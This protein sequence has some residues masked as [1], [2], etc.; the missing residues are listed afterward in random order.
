MQVVDLYVQ[1]IVQL[2]VILTDVISCPHE[3][4]YISK[5]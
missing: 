4:D 5:L 2:A 1:P 3:H